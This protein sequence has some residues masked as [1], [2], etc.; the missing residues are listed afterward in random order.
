M[1]REMRLQIA[2][3]VI[4][5]AVL[6][7]FGGGCRSSAPSPSSGDPAPVTIVSRFS[8]ERA[9]K[10]LEALAAIG[11]RAVGTPGAEQ[12]RA[13]I[14]SE[15]AVLGLEAVPVAADMH[16]GPEEAPV[17]LRL[18]N[19]EATMPSESKD[20]IV[21]M[22]P[23]DSAYHESFAFVGV[24]DGASGSAVLL[25]LARVFAE[26]PLPYATKLIFLDGEAE[27]GRGSEDDL[28]SDLLGSQSAASI[29]KQAGAF[30]RMRLLLYLN[31]VSDADL[32]IARDRFSHRI[33]RDA[34]W[35]AAGR[36][37]HR[38]VFPV[39]TQ[40]EAPRSGHR[41]FF[42]Q[43]M[44]RVIT[45]EDTGFHEGEGSLA[46]YT[47]DDTLARSSQESLAI[48]GSVVLAGLRD[49][50]AS[51][52]RIDRFAE[53]PSLPEPSEPAPTSAPEPAVAPSTAPE[54]APAP[55]LEAVPAPIPEAAPAPT[56]D[57]APATPDTAPETTPPKV[58]D[59]G[60]TPESVPSPGEA[61]AS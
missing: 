39:D 31:R 5:I 20:V 34:F 4:S 40:Y 36:L 57:A 60:A 33:Y 29:L 21:L 23:Y 54:E 15:L 47:E 37:G 58:D 49:I 28:T 13:Y 51:L 26:N 56:S 12:A 8:G 41:A 22:A 35:K 6:G 24:N 17:A 45:I 10:H 30:P 18:V 1:R 42:D 7:S 46:R 61:P 16:Y 32:L 52:Q 44:R 38:D 55:A 9:W 11:P 25:E 53:A 43:G 59:A 50:A 48:V 19:L 2:V 3:F 14:S 27:F